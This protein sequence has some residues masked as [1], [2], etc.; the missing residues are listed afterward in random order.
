MQCVSTHPTLI[1]ST[2][3]LMLEN[4]T[5]QGKVLDVD[6]GKVISIALRMTTM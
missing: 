4:F 1:V 5:W 6:G 3:C 2:L